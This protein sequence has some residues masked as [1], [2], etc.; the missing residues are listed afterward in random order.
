MT[1][2]A[3][4]DVLDALIRAVQRLPRALQLKASDY[5]AIQRVPVQSQQLEKSFKTIV[6]SQFHAQTY[7][8]T[9]LVNKPV[10]FDQTTRFLNLDG[11]ARGTLRKRQVV[12]S[13]PAPAQKHSLSAI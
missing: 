4:Y 12:K 1:A 6:P 8:P 13:E 7:S 9:E 5:S 11:T 2:Q 10:L 3:L